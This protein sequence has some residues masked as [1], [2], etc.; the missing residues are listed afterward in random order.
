MV[1][2]SLEQIITFKKFYK[3]V[4]HVYDIHCIVNFLQKPTLYKAINAYWNNPS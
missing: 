2:F 3:N 4:K 1:I